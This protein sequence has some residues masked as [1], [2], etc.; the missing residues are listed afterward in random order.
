MSCELWAVSREQ[1]RRPTFKS[2]PPFFSL[3]RILLKCWFRLF[4]FRQ[5]VTFLERASKLTAMSYELWATSNEL[6]TNSNKSFSQSANQPVNH[7]TIQPFNHSTIQPVS[8]SASQPFN[9]STIQP[10]S[11]S[12]IQQFNHS[13]I[14]QFNH[15]TIHRRRHSTWNIQPSS[16]VFRFYS[17]KSPCRISKWRYF[18]KIPFFDTKP[19]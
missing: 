9:N 11:H 5:L 1:K 4:T 12:A 6:W 7:S 15:L 3:V 16:K 14:Q 18:L 13:A 10:F 8:H 2:W 19:R 17:I